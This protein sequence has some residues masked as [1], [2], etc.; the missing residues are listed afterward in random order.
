MPQDPNERKPGAHAAPSRRGV[1]LI[2]LIVSMLLLGLLSSV[3]TLAVRRT[4]P[5]RGDDPM[6]D[7]SDSSLASVAAHRRISFPLVVDGRRA[8]ATVLPDGSVIADSSLHINP[9]DGHVA[10]AR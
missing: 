7:V 1:T 5:R 8:W 2:E 6:A 10:T 9:L 4:V 3:A